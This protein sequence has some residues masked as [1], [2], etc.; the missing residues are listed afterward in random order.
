M[1]ACDTNVLVYAHREE[2]PLHRAA[3]ERLRE[4]AEGL[5]PWGVPVFCL[6]EFLRVTTHRKILTPPSTLDQ[7]L[8]FLAG[9]AASPTFRCLLPDA[10][11]PS[12][13]EE[14]VRGA[15]AAGNLAF[16][17]QI[18]AVCSLHGATLLTADRDFARF[19]IA[20]DSLADVG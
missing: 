4:L 7:A 20:T 9:I 8:S 13:L 1:I 10:T 16:D 19:A 12:S 11:F 14:V 2:F 3:L 5:A 18:A 6:G 15:G 17:A